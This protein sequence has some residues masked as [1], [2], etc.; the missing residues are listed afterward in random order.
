M[1]KPS[2][3]PSKDKPDGRL[4]RSERSRRLIIDATQELVGEG[5]LV[6]TAQQI[7]DRA[8]VGIRTLFRHFADMESLYATMDTEL[9]DGYEGMFLGGGRAGALTERILHAMESRALAYEKLYPLIQSTRAQMWRSAV[10]RKNYARNQRGLR[11][12]L[13]AWLPEMLELPESRRQAVEAAA[14]FETWDRLRT[15]QGLSKKA[16][17]NTVYEMV[18]LL[19]GAG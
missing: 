13:A 11:R 19:F 14:S 9:R 2:V 10:L 6:P 5:V 3:L 15:H 12:D 8:G 18:C 16:S 4:Q 1:G 17:L 7:A